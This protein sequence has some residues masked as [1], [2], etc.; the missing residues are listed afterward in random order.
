MLDERSQRKLV[1]VHPDLIKVVQ[2]AAEVYDEDA[3]GMH[4]IVTEG[5]RTAERQGMLFKTGA[6]QTMYSRHLT[7]HAVDLAC[8]LR[9]E[10]RWDW[11]LYYRLADVV[12]GSALELGVKIIWGGDWATFKDGPH[13]ELDRVAYPVQTYNV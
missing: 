6:S 4:F 1:G 13:F 9:G 7:G 12:K 5:L 2:R 10:V 3:N 8:K 11:P